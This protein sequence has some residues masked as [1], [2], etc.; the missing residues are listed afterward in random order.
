MVQQ[1]KSTGRKQPRRLFNRYTEKGLTMPKISKYFCVY[2]SKEYNEILQHIKQN[3]SITDKGNC[4]LIPCTGVEE[5]VYFSRLTFDP[6]FPLS[7][8][9]SLFE[10]DIPTQYIQM[11]FAFQ[12]EDLKKTLGFCNIEQENS[13]LHLAD[14]ND[15]S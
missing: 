5:G 15:E 6:D 4:L 2:V 13:D 10:I 14:K 8:Q 1:I 3:I 7:K 12:D 9:G 11:I